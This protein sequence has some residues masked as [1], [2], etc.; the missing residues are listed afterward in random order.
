MDKEVIKEKL[1]QSTMKGLNFYSN[2]AQSENFKHFILDLDC[3]ELVEPD[4]DSLRKHDVPESL[5]ISFYR[6]FDSLI[7]NI[8]EKTCIYF[9]EFDQDLATTV[10]DSINDFFIHDV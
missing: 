5:K 3:N 10:F 1:I 9:F 4:S 8:N 6:K 2:I 7:E